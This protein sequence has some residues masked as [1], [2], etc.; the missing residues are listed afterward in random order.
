MSLSYK[1]AQ[2]SLHELCSRHLGSERNMET[3]R[4]RAK[5]PRPGVSIAA[6]LLSA[7]IAF[8]SL[9]IPCHLGFSEA[10]PM[11]VTSLSNTSLFLGYVTVGMTSVAYPVTLKNIGNAT[12]SITKLA[13]TGT[14]AGNF[15]ESNNCGRSVPVGTSCTISL[16]FTPSASGLRNAA[17]SITDDAPGGSQTVGLVG[18]AIVP[19]IDLSPSSLSFAS[20][21]LGTTSA[22]QSI[23]V[24]NLGSGILLITKL[25]FTGTDSGDFAQTNSC[26]N[27]VATGGTCTIK[28]TY[29]PKADG[30]REASFSMTDNATGSPQTIGLSGTGTGSS[31]TTSTPPT[32]P[33]AS[34]STTSLDFGSQ[35]IATT[36]AAQTVILSNGGGAALSISSLAIS[37]ANASDFAEVADTCGS[38]LAAG[39]TCTIEVTFTPSA[40][41]QGTATLSVTDNASGSPQ[42]VSFTGTGSPDVILSWVASPTSGVVGYYVYRGTSSGEESSNALNSAPING[43]RYVDGNVSPGTTYYYAVT[44]VGSNGTQSARSIETEAKVPSS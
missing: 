29:K 38:S 35:P 33:A 18:A 9:L 15:A 6:T 42:G 28:V 13:I 5:A 39:D 12:L 11:P 32:S 27:S 26:G 40:A 8:S 24:S 22:A 31:G 23:T 2:S 19:A 21:S 10:S 30:S 44:S 20:R 7:I 4:M 41:G 1:T 37:G 25:E 34:L 14:D 17:L 16:T 43:T 36:S 3:C